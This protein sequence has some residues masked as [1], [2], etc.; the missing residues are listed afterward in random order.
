MPGTFPKPNAIARTHFLCAM[1][2]GS[3]W[4]R[5]EPWAYWCLVAI[6]LLPI[7]VPRW[8]VTLDGPSHLYSARIVRE[9][10]LGDPFFSQFFHLAPYPVPYWLGHAVMAV[11]LGFLPAPA[12]GKLMWGTAVVLM[13]LAGRFLVRVIAPQRAWASLLIMPFLLHYALR[14]GFLNFCLSLPLLLFALA[15]AWQGMMDGKGRP[16]RLSVVLVLLY[17][18]HLYTFLLGACLLLSM[19]A[20]ALVVSRGKNL[21]NLR[22]PAIAIGAAL[23]LPLGLAAGYFAAQ[24]AP[25][26]AITRLP[27]HIL[28][29]WVLEGRCWNGLG[30][31]GEKLASMLTAIPLLIAG[32]AMFVVRVLK[33]RWGAPAW[34]DYWPLIALAAVAAYFLVP[35]VVG[36]GSSVS[37][38]TLLLVLL[39]L[40]CSVAASPLPPKALIPLVVLV[41]LADLYHT[42][43]QY[44]SAISLGRECDELM[45][46]QPAVKD[47]SVLLPLNWSGNWMHSNLS[48]YLGTGRA[49]VV[50][51]DHFTALAPFNPAQW[52]TAMLPYAAVGN[53]DRSN[54][55]CVHIDGY[56]KATGTAIDEVL[57]WKMNAAPPDSC[58][59]DVRRQLLSGF[60]TLAVSPRGDAVLYSRTES[61]TK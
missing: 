14:L 39:L 20:W 6:H 38:R 41:V 32:L 53:F 30:V 29:Q 57:A 54:R 43:L 61:S 8:F 60:D 1:Q 28:G 50:V 34:N 56:R 16:F 3:R 2:A 46:V 18:A 44:R 12:V 48:N 24:H 35:D 42:R 15:W 47:R 9:L 5:I 10:V 22:R 23:A 33:L 21:G 40:A 31:E 45:A 55:P 25:G 13:A 58:L 11:L 51:L 4:K 17:F 37:Q 52:N 7:V 26:A 36:G 27:M 59:E 49:R 19:L